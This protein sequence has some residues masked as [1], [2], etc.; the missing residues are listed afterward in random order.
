MFC[1]YFRRICILLLLDEM[2]YICWLGL[3][4]GRA[5]AHALKYRWRETVDW[6]QW[7]CD[8]T[9]WTF[10]IGR[11]AGWAAQSNGATN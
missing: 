2:F 6:A 11:A 1:V 5:I 7:S 8:S 9:G 10:S 3:W 4:L